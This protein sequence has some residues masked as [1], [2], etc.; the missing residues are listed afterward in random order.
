MVAADADHTPDL[1]AE[2]LHAFKN[3]PPAATYV[4]SR[5]ELSSGFR[6]ESFSADDVLKN[7]Q[8]AIQRE[9]F[10]SDLRP[11]LEKAKQGKEL[12]NS[13]ADSITS[14]SLR[15]TSVSERVALLKSLA[16][17]KVSENDVSAIARIL[18]HDQYGLKLI[19]ESAQQFFQE[20]TKE[21][22]EIFK[23]LLSISPSQPQKK[24]LF[25]SW[26]NTQLKELTASVS[27]ESERAQF[28]QNDLSIRERLEVLSFV[29]PTERMD[30]AKALLSLSTSEKSYHDFITDKLDNTI[31]QLPIS[32]RVD[33]IE[34]ALVQNRTGQI[35]HLLRASNSI[36]ELVRTVDAVGTERLL[37]LNITAVTEMVAQS[38]LVPVMRG[39]DFGSHANLETLEEITSAHAH[40]KQTLASIPEIIASFP[41]IQHTAAA[42]QYL[43]TYVSDLIELGEEA[44]KFSENVTSY[45]DLIQRYTLMAELEFFY[46]VD[47][48][49][50]DSIKSSWSD[51]LDEACTLSE[52]GIVIGPDELQDTVQNEQRLEHWQLKHLKQIGEVLRAVP[53]AELLFTPN[54]N[55]IEL[56]ESLG[57]YVLGARFVNGVIQIADLTLDHQGIENSYE[58]TE[59]L[60]V[61]L[62]HEIGH[63]VQI[64]DGPSNIY[65]PR[66]GNEPYFGKGEEIHDFDEWL[67][68]SDWKV[69]DRKR[70]ELADE[71]GYIILDGEKLPLEKPVAFDGQNIVLSYSSWGNV[72]Q[73]YDADSDFSNRWYAKTSPWEDFA[74]AFS[75]YLFLPERLIED[76][77][78]KFQHLELELRRYAGDAE[79]REKL[80]KRLEEKRKEEAAYGHDVKGK[81]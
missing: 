33:L 76:A 30:F 63:G 61:V 50:K 74:E 47:I 66:D 34:T 20:L 32:E 78:E 77:P 5:E 54:L 13:E 22:L 58:G 43:S 69:Y 7:I 70:Y 8:D 59:S 52:F 45:R 36:E 16:S 38:I 25:D 80:E 60:L 3:S 12:S 17:G 39:I 64:G 19:D 23:A 24:M 41:A 53:E 46:G 29:S 79:L 31:G 44:Q 15:H 51:L 48:S 18:T 62:A 68:L 49:A 27:N 55:R 42:Q 11:V 73:S 35:E 21:S 67:K 56:V 1:I 65:F 9:H 14:E 6:G 71:P 28:A 2:T 4:A 40:L 72:L 37:D 57:Q 10:R 81:H 75:E 26:L